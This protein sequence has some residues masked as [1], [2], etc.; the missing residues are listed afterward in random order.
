MPRPTRLP[1]LAVPLA[2]VTAAGLALAG[3]TARLTVRV[4][5]VADA[6]GR[7]CVDLFAGEDGFPAKRQKAAQSRCVAARAGTVTVAF[8]VAPGDYAAFAFH[9]A[10]ADGRLETNFIGMPKEGVGASN[11]AKGR[12][13]PPSFAQARF[14]VPEAGAAIAFRLKYL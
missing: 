6:A 8:D 10:D 7:V 11:N 9:D 5:Q 1:R 4:D 2:L 12:M 14:A 3:G 13:G